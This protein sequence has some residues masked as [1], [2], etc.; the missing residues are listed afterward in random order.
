[1]NRQNSENDRLLCGRADRV[2]FLLA[3]LIASLVTGMVS[4]QLRVQAEKE[5]QEHLAQEVLRFHILANSD[6]DEDQ[7]LKMT[8][9]EEVLGYLEGAMPEDMDVAETTDWMRRHTDEL[10]NLSREIVQQEGYDY[11][12]SA[13]V[14]TC[15]FPEKTYGD[16]T[17]P[18]GN[19]EALRIEI[20][21][22]K[23]HNWWCVLYPN[24]CFLDAVNAVVPKEGKQELK[25]VLSE[26]EYSQITATTDFKIKWYFPERLK[27]LWD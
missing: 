14:T 2:N 23:G 27:E 5:T 15:W 19:Y 8:V 21:A 22:A 7:A 11:P 26:E 13:A 16:L 12:V 1:M 3:L 20:G 25:N 24:L 9:K 18:S 10:E 6:S 4:R 17:F